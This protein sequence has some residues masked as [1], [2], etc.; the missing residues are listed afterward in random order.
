MA[1]SKRNEYDRRLT[2]D[3]G[4]YLVAW[5]LNRRGYIAQRF[6]TESFDVIA[7]ETS[8]IKDKLFKVGASPFYIQ[9]KTME[10]EFKQSHNPD[11][12]EIDKIVDRAKVMGISPDSIYFVIGFFEKDIRNVNYWIIP[13]NEMGCLLGKTKK[14]YNL[15]RKILDK[16]YVNSNTTKI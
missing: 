16:I 4:E 6:D 7:H 8:Y 13:I 10:K 12:R 15:S 9:V 1:D 11:I 2:G 5:L 3:T 14:S